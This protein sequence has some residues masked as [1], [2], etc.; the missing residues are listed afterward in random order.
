ER[1]H[2]WMNRFRR[3]LI[4][5]EKQAGSYLGML[6]LACAVICFQRT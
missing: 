1:S 5:W 3:L 4:R 2:S 6:Q